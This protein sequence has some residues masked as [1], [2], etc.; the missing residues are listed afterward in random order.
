MLIQNH[1]LE[2]IFYSNIEIDG[3]E[4]EE[5]LNSGKKKQQYY[6]ICILKNYCRF[7]INIFTNI[8]AKCE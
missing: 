5:K 1:L 7:D 4:I 2:H 8:Q 3:T 6:L